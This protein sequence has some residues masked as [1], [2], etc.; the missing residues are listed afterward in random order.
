MS[1]QLHPGL[2]GEHPQQSLQGSNGSFGGSLEREFEGLFSSE[3]SIVLD[4]IVELKEELDKLRFDSQDFSK[5][6]GFKTEKILQR[7][8]VFEERLNMIQRETQDKW[9][10]LSGRVRE[11]HMGEAKV[12]TIIERHNQIIQQFDLRLS[13]ATKLIDNQSLAIVKQQEIIDDARRQIE[14]LK[15]L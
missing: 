5:Q 4:K 8:T 13:Q 6:H 14:R 7:L 12:E 10:E 3:P 2:F 15:K 11:K 9:A 1:R